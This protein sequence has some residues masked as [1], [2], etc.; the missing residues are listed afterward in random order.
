MAG[1]Y[2]PGGTGEIYKQVALQLI[3]QA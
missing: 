1:H 2:C 3:V